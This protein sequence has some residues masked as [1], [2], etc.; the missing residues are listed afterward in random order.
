MDGRK[1]QS[2][3]VAFPAITLTHSESSQAFENLELS[4]KGTFE[5]TQGR[6]EVLLKK[7]Q[8]KK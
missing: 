2:S 1:V 3:A 6:A 5:E 4:V 8:E 7:S